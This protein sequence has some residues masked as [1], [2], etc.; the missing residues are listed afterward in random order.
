MT[1]VVIGRA[2]TLFI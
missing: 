1:F 2:G